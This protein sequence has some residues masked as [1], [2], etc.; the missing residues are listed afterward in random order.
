MTCAR[1]GPIFLEP[2]KLTTSNLVCSMRLLRPLI[3]TH[4]TEK[5][6]LD[7][8][9][10]LPNICGLLFIS[11]AATELCD[12]KV[13]VQ[14]GVAKPIIKTPNEKTGLGSGLEEPV[15]MF[16]QQEKWEW[17]CDRGAAMHLVFSFIFLCYG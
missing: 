1:G 10:G 15:K 14:R 7:L 3:K 17:D 12:S 6:G 16:N 8:G 4:L 5:V 9:L 2:L 13:V 11:H